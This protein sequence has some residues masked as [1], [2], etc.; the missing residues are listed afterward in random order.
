M[1]N[2]IPIKIKNEYLVLPL[3]L[4]ATSSGAPEATHILYLRRHQPRI[5]TPNDNRTLFVSNLPAD[6]TDIHLRTL[7][8]SLGGGRV[9]SVS[10]GDSVPASVASTAVVTTNKK[11]KRTTTTPGDE[12]APT[13]AVAE[14]NTW[15]RSLHRSG[16][17]GLVVFVDNASC[18]GTLRA[19]DKRRKSKSAPPPVWGN[20]VA[21]APALGIARYA[22]HH[23]LRFPTS[24]QLQASVDAFMAAFGEAEKAAKLQAAKRRTVVDEDGFVTVTRGG[25]VK[26]ATQEAAKAALEEKEKRKGELKGFYRFQI[27]EEKKMRQNELLAKFEEDRKRVEE[28]KKVK[29]FRPE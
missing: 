23:R 22:A 28:R 18:V 4:P 3:S 13:A 15:D 20:D 7:F 12:A 10:F 27:R 2:S 19:I 25:R 8:S 26:P 11:R 24:T 6:A 14:I 29:K 21:G 16:T 17:N 9:E 1:T 5:P